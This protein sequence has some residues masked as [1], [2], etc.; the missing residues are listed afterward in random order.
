MLVNRSFE[1]LLRQLTVALLSLL[2]TLG[3][4]LVGYSCG[5]G[6]LLARRLELSLL[7]F[8]HAQNSFFVLQY[9]VSFTDLW[10]RLGTASSRIRI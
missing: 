9:V 5:I 7:L 10:R 3:H 6:A 8:D 2:P 1:E 4:R